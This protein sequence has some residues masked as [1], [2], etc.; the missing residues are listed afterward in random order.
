MAT[1]AI[2]D[3]NETRTAQPEKNARPL[4]A[5]M[6]VA[7]G[8]FRLVPHPYNMEGVGALGLFAGARLRSWR[9]YAVPLV[10][11][12]VTDALLKIPLARMG[13]PTVTWATPFVYG[14]FLFNVFLGQ[15][16]LRRTNSPVRIAA[17]SLLA[18]IQ[19]FVVSNFGV[20]ATGSGTLYPKNL[21]G[22]LTCYVAAI[23]FFGTQAPPLGFFGNMLL[24][25]LF[26]AGLLFGAYAWLGR[27]EAA[28]DRVGTMPHLG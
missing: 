4:A 8:F 25:D 13:Y 28:T 12:A 23:P 20:W 27:R 14:S 11:M 9:A 18:S 1:E 7:A 24:G 17:A 22:L 6:A 16:L 2:M 5:A 19:F 21:S 15:V 10:V 3:T 26:F